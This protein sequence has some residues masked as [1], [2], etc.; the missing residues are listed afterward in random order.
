[1]LRWMNQ[2]KL[3]EVESERNRQR[4]KKRK[5][6]Q[7]PMDNPQYNDSNF[8]RQLRG[9]QLFSMWAK[10][11][12][13]YAIIVEFLD[14][15]AKCLKW[16]PSSAKYF[17]KSGIEIN[18]KG[19][20]SLTAAASKKLYKMIESKLFAVKKALTQ[21][22]SSAAIPKLFWDDEQQASATH[23]M[24]VTTVPRGSGTAEM[25]VLE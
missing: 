18:Q 25:I 8:L 13:V 7:A 23:G 12:S 14:F 6:E 11:S 4:D 24:K 9:N 15:E 5:L 3:H 1:M 2:K 17:T 21:I 16:Y 19:N 10:D 20:G 22:P